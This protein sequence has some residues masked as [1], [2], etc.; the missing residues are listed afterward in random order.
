MITQQLLALIPERILNVPHYCVDIYPEI[1][2]LQNGYATL[3]LKSEYFEYKWPKWPE[4]TYNY[5]FVLTAGYTTNSL[6][7]PLIPLIP[8]NLPKIYNLI[9]D[10]FCSNLILKLGNSFIRKKSNCNCFYLNDTNQY[11]TIK[12]HFKPIFDNSS[13]YSFELHIAFSNIIT[14]KKGYKRAKLTNQAENVHKSGPIKLASLSF[15]NIIH[16]KLETAY[17]VIEKRFEDCLQGK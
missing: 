17:Q 4:I 13:L 9:V 8:E 15:S 2:T 14:T 3:R 5:K 6:P 12:D 7:H 11:L 10:E 16:K 1:P